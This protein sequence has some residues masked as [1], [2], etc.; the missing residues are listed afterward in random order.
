MLFL[1]LKINPS[2]GLNVLVKK[3]QHRVP[4]PLIIKFKP[5]EWFVLSLPLLDIV[6]HL[7]DNLIYLLLN[8]FEL[9]LEGSQLKK[10]A[11][12][13][14][15]FFSQGGV[16]LGCINKWMHSPEVLN[17]AVCPGE[18][19]TSSGRV[20]SA[21]CWESAKQPTRNGR[22]CIDFRW[23]WPCH[24]D[25]GHS[26]WK[27]NKTRKPLLLLYCPW[28]SQGVLTTLFEMLNSGCKIC[29]DYNHETLETL[30]F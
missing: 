7:R 15:S 26:S 28:L 20:N 1:S 30:S 3:G 18:G 10:E 14:C 6:F 12:C 13:Y 19:H 24:P 29:L 5:R 17:T 21:S 8:V 22:N 11:C 25:F 27:L 2:H 16:W 9:A 4:V 23:Q